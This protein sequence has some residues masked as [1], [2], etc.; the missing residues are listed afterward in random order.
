MS[1]PA[2]DLWH[3][4]LVS[5][6]KVL[7]SGGFSDA[8]IVKRLRHAR[9]LADSMTMSP[10]DVE[11]ADL[12]LWIQ[13]VSDQRHAQLDHRTSL[14]HFYR[15]AFKT[16]RIFTDP[17]EEPSRRATAREMPEAWIA[18]LKGYRG[19]LRAAGRPETTV[20]MRLFQLRAFA[21]ENASLAPYETD[22]DDLIEWLSHKRWSAEYRRAF[23]AAFR[24]FFTW[25]HEAG[26]MDTNPALKLPVVRASQPRPR[27]V[28]DT[29]YRA[30]LARADDREHLMLRLAAE[31]G[32][33]AGEVCLVNTSDV[34]GN[35]GS[36]ELA[37][38]GK[39]NKERVLPL[40][41][42]LAA[43]IVSQDEGYVFP[44]KMQG[45]LS[46]HTT[47]TLISRLLPEG[48]TMHALRHRF[49]SRAY[50]IDRDVFMVQQALGHA[51]P[52]TTQRYVKMSDHGMRQLMETVSRTEAVA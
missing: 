1:T 14:R 10:W 4:A 12:K 8:T 51:S 22:M 29:A 3:D 32:L 45:H 48:V 37:V 26:R 39:G 13:N 33:R 28:Q 16:G 40:T 49:A 50:A 20:Q 21:Y 43:L 2:E 24:S 46:S 52:E 18:P 19:Y 27:P 42:G 36:Y 34:L 25:A 47:G 5:Y 35:H 31:L 15:W 17:S 41:D 6:E 23:R 11:H 38:H 7:R 30:A 9:R 44:G